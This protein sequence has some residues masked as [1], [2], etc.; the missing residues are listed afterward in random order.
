MWYSFS[1]LFLP[2]GGM[3]DFHFMKKTFHFPNRFLPCTQA[4]WVDAHHVTLYRKMHGGVGGACIEERDRSKPPTPQKP[5]HN[6]KAIKYLASP[7]AK[8]AHNL[9]EVNRITDHIAQA[10]TYTQRHMNNAWS[11]MVSSTPCLV[12]YCSFSTWFI[13]IIWDNFSPS[14][15]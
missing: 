15:D 13:Q 6:L 8:W 5:S 12:F 7:L 4:T 11:E 10:H 9:L 2:Y 1:L 14:T 3:N